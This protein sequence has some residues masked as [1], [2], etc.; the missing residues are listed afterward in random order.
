MTQS[1][2]P[3]ENLNPRLD[4]HNLIEAAGRIAED[5][6][7]TAATREARVRETADLASRVEERFDAYDQA[8]AAA[9]R[10]KEAS[11]IRAR[12]LETL[13]EA[14]RADC[15]QAIAEAGRRHHAQIQATEEAHEERM[16]AADEAHRGDIERL[17]G[18]LD[19]LKE[20]MGL[21]Y[22]RLEEENALQATEI[23]RVSE[24]NV[25]LNR[26]IQML[27]AAVEAS[28]RSMQDDDTALVAAMA[29]VRER[30]LGGELPPGVVR[31]PQRPRP[32]EAVVVQQAP[33]VVP[34]Q[35]R[36]AG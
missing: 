6:N 14:T 16:N 36:A 30:T 33:Q 28:S 18:N 29:G 34:A 20:D 1:P 7:R 11:D 26:S 24:E 4:A 21:R 22:L 27:I 12:E 13:V 19:R 8:L 23:E 25:S 9:R 32:E 10:A 15:E 35:S 2:T 31:L 3:F 5:L 17:R